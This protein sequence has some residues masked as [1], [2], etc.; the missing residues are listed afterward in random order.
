MPPAKAAIETVMLLT[1]M[2]G[3]TL[4]RRASGISVPGVRSMSERRASSL[5]AEDATSGWMIP[6]ANVTIA[7][8]RDERERDEGERHGPARRRRQLA[9]DE[10]AQP[11]AARGRLAVHEGVGRRDEV[12]QSL[13]DG[14]PREVA[15][16]DRKVARRAAIEGAELEDLLRRQPGDPSAG[17]LDERAEPCPARAAILDEAVDGLNRAHRATVPC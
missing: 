8:S 3:P 2:S 13:G 15:S 6:A 12:V 16:R 10:T 11:P 9:G 14:V 5:S 4:A 1:M 17:P 7:G